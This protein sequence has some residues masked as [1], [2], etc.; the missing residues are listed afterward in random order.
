MTPLLPTTTKPGCIHLVIGY[1]LNEMLGSVP[2][3][4]TFVGSPANPQTL[5]NIQQ[6]VR[7]NAMEV[8]V[9]T[10][11]VGRVYRFDHISELSGGVVF[12]YTYLRNH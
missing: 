7:A 8:L 6:L 11:G 2:G 9:E 10:D 12:V 4:A 5:I 1:T 3:L